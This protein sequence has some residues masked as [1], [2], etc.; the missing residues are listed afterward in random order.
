MKA[1]RRPRS[2]LRHRMVDQYERWAREDEAQKAAAR[3]D[4][5][6]RAAAAQA[7]EQTA[8]EIAQAIGALITRDAAQCEC[9]CGERGTCASCRQL[10]Q[11]Q[12]DMVEA[13]RI[14]GLAP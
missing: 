12:R 2:G 4:E 3:Q 6:V 8:R 5:A 1:R 11:G 14:G 10:L 13:L 7:R 9:E